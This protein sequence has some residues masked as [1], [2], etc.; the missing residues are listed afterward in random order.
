MHRDV[1]KVKVVSTFFLFTLSPSRTSRRIEP[2]SMQ[3]TGQASAQRSH[4]MQSVI[5]FSGSRVNLGAPRNPS[6]TRAGSSGYCSVYMAWFGLPPSRGSYIARAVYLKGTIKTLNKAINNNSL[7][8][9]PR[10][11]LAGCVLTADINS[12]LQN[13]LLSAF[14]GLRSRALLQYLFESLAAQVHLKL[15]LLVEIEVARALVYRRQQTPHDWNCN[16]E[17]GN[18]EI[19]D[20]CSGR[21]QSPFFL[22]HPTEHTALGLRQCEHVPDTGQDYIGEPGRYHPFPAKLHELIVAI[23]RP[24][25]PKPHVC[26]DHQSDFYCENGD[27]QNH[28]QR[29][30][31]N[32]AKSGE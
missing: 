24:R 26:V 7:I 18:D 27:A 2:T 29:R 21:N 12:P 6:D 14:C 32:I 23:A 4:A 25:P 11:L 1:S 17:A 9:K 3:S 15:S 13:F 31:L 30:V 28:K 8:K 20:P 16:D 19:N 5:P 10:V 22:V